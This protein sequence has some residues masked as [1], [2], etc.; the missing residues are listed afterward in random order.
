MENNS[1]NESIAD[2]SDTDSCHYTDDSAASDAEGCVFNIVYRVVIVPL[3]LLTAELELDHMHYMKT[4]TACVL[5]T[6][7]RRFGHISGRKL[8]RF[9]KYRMAKG[10]PEYD[11]SHG[12]MCVLS[13]RQVYSSS[14]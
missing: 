10:L 1:Q 6:L 14:N 12:S 8:R 13:P 9:V 2:G 5:L 4:A 11:P 3:L 7:H